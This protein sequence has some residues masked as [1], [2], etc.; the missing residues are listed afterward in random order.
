VN[1]AF[2]LAA[3]WRGA[4]VGVLD[5]DIFGPSVP[6][7]MGLGGAPEPLLTSCMCL[8]TGLLTPR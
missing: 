1:L 2:A 3:H 7:L 6:R 8:F 4:R 5:L